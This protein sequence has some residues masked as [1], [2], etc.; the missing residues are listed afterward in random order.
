MPDQ[1]RERVIEM[2]DA[3]VPRMQQDLLL[4]GSMRTQLPADLRA[5]MVRVFAQVLARAVQTADSTE[6]ATFTESLMWE[7]RKLGVPARTFVRWV[8]RYQIITEAM[9][10][11]AEWSIVQPHLA[12]ARSRA[13]RLQN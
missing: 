4:A 1:L 5:D 11:A 2:L 9:M 13:I 3:A 10:T 7:A 8:D 12:E 6:L